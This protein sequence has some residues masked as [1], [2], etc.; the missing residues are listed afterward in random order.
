[1]VKKQKQSGGFGK[2]KTGTMER[3]R[4]FILS[5]PVVSVT[6]PSYWSLAIAATK[7]A[8]NKAKMVLPAYIK[9]PLVG[10]K[11]WQMYGFL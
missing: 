11:G 4:T 10:G 6:K 3:I 1:M 2:E 7:I 5:M 8:K 9:R